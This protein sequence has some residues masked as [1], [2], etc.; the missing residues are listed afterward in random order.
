MKE[1]LVSIVVV[2]FVASFASYIAYPSSMEKSAKCAIMAVV[3]FV[4]L[5][6]VVSLVGSIA[7]FKAEDFNT[8]DFL[9]GEDFEGEYI[10]VAEE[11]F[12]IGIKRLISD[13]FGIAESEAAV[14]VMGFDFENMKAKKINI[15]LSGKAAF[16]DYRSIEECVEK[17]GL[18]ECEV[19]ISFGK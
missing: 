7:D 11:A 14:V 12:S 2:S 3:I 10:K 5:S 13:K 18:G 4:T 6:P 19:N 9:P 15:I 17:N 1:Y 16:A 8:E